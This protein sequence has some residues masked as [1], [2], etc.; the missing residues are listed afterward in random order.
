[1]A[2]RAT[3]PCNK[4]SHD[5]VSKPSVKVNPEQHLYKRTLRSLLG[6]WEMSVRICACSYVC[7]TINSL[8]HSEIITEGVTMEPFER[9]HNSGKH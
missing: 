6:K 9:H 8:S 4:L 3:M 2:L 1:M 5:G 7:S